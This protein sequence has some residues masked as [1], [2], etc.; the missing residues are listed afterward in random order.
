VRRLA[1]QCGTLDVSQLYG[2]PLPVTAIGLGVSLAF[3][4]KG[5]VPVKVEFPLDRFH[6]ILA[7][8]I[9]DL[10]QL[11]P[12][13]VCETTSCTHTTT[14]IRCQQFHGETLTL[15]P[16]ATAT[17]VSAAGYTHGECTSAQLRGIP[18]NLNLI[19][20]AMRQGIYLDGGSNWMAQHGMCSCCVRVVP[21]DIA[22]G[23]SSIS[24]EIRYQSTRSYGGV[25]VKFY[26]S[27]PR[28]YTDRTPVAE[29]N[30]RWVPEPVC[31]T[32]N[33][34]GR[35]PRYPTYRTLGGSHEPLCATSC[36]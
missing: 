19:R 34:R 16:P 4:R 2:P 23:K 20:R 29:D 7:K 15:I 33:H 26:Q 24:S 8:Q 21:S 25:E 9:K 10:K 18:R 3:P 35:S 30:I 12:A 11:N 22:H 36:R 27:G 14:V 32:C 1:T 28:H 17:L 31:A 6:G 13:D 5:T